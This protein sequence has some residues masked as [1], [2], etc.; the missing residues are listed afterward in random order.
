[1]QA[2]L[3]L[4]LLAFTHATALPRT[5]DSGR[6]KFSWPHTQN[7]L[8]FGDSYSFVQGTRGYAN[9]SFIGD[10]FD[11]PFTP[12]ELLSDEII[13]KNTSSDGSNWAEFLT[14]CYSGLP[15]KCAPH[16]LWD[17]AFAGADITKA[18]LAPHH[19]FT[20]Q[21]VDSVNQWVKY[22]ADVLN[23][24]GE[25][26]LVA[27]WIGI[28]DT[29]DSA[30]F[31]NITDWRAYWEAEMSAYFS[32]VSLVHSKGL[33]N[34]LFINVPPEERSPAWV[35]GNP[36]A[37]TLKAH[38]NLYNDVLAE[39]INKWESEHGDVNV[40]QFDAHGWWNYVLDHYLIYGFK[41]ITGYCEC[42]DDSYFWYNTGHP[43]EK[44]HK[45]LAGD[46]ERKLLGWSG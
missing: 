16:K 34:H 36:G 37:T 1:M 45:L 26:T 18:I 27:W 40:F 7:L 6:P 33:K 42:T 5:A 24:S 43:V 46:M 10:A 31:S 22:A 12:E 20:L 19:N 15:A 4:S 35:N 29:G 32:A 21:M 17:F 25:D 30:G 14:G 3:L 2:L 41:N 13:P 23:L 39:S 38:I 44:V 28:N 9:Y 8:I 11:V